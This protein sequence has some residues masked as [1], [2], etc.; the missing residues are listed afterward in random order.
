M[1]VEYSY[2]VSHLS[3]VIHPPILALPFSSLSEDRVLFQDLRDETC[4]YRSG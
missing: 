1:I 2:H 4:G 3:V